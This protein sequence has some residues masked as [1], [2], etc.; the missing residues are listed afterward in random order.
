MEVEIAGEYLR[1]QAEHTSS[2]RDQGHRAVFQG[3]RGPL[4]FQ[5]MSDSLGLLLQLPAV[6][7]CLVYL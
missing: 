1:E 7:R 6:S 5:G 4:R 3:P 2:A